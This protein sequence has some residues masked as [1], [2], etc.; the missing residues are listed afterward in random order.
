MNRISLISFSV[1]TINASSTKITSWVLLSIWYFTGDWSFSINMFKLEISEVHE[2]KVIMRSVIQLMTHF[3][4]NNFL[5]QLQISRLMCPK[6]CSWPRS[7]CWSSLWRRWGD[8]GPQH[9]HNK[10]VP[11][12]LLLWSCYCCGGH[13]RGNSR[14]PITGLWWSANQRPGLCQLDQWES[15]GM[16]S[17]LMGW[18]DDHMGLLQMGRGSDRSQQAFE[19]DERCH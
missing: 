18:D 11:P 3:T 17:Y 5:V 13:F 9:H 8:P 14:Q 19:I 2:K 16:S 7:W 4:G 1:P 12:P 6:P 15:W 10:Q